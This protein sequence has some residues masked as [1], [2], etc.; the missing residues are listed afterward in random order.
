VLTSKYKGLL[1]EH[2]WPLNEAAKTAG[3]I[4]RGDVAVI[5][6]TTVQR[7]GEPDTEEVTR[8]EG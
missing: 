2:Q 7:I 3:F 6:H 1:I 4:E 8:I 5:L